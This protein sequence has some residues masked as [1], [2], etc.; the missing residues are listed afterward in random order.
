MV[1]SLRYAQCY[2]PI[3]KRL[4]S[5]IL[6]SIFV[7]IASPVFFMFGFYVIPVFGG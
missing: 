2:I 7:G 3:F 6:H 1:Q 5:V 4:Q